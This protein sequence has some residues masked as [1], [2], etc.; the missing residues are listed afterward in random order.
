MLLHNSEGTASPRV[1]ATGGGTDVTT[2]SNW[3]SG[4]TWVA[5][6]GPQTGLSA[7]VAPGATGINAY[8]PD[9]VETGNYYCQGIPGM[10]TSCPYEEPSGSMPVTTCNFTISPGSISGAICNGT[11]V[12]RQTFQANVTP[13]LSA[14]AFRPSLSSCSFSATG[15]ILEDDADSS[16]DMTSTQALCIAAYRAQPPQGTGTAGTITFDMTLQL[17]G[18]SVRHTQPADVECQ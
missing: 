18:S 11:S 17:G 2:Q 9:L 7:G 12:N 6:V 1:P 13:S 3:S 5:T 16:N 4:N 8:Y 10:P 14:C 15:Y